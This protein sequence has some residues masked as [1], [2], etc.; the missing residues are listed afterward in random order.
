VAVGVTVG[1]DPVGGEGDARD[2]AT[3]AAPEA[4]DR[5]L[6][7]MGPKRLLIAGLFNF[8]LAIFAVLFGLFSQ[9]DDV[10]PF[11]PFSIDFWASV[12]AGTQLEAWVANHQW[13]AAVGGAITV[14][15]LGIATGIV[16]T[17][18]RDYGFRL[19]RT[20]RG[21]RRRRGL[22]TRTD[23]TVPAARVQAAVV[24]TG[25]IRRL[26]GWYDVRLSSLA[27]DGKDEA[28]HLVGPLVTLSEADHIIG[29][30]G[31]DRAGF[32]DGVGDSAQWQRQHKAV[33]LVWPVL[34]IG[35]AALMA[36]AGQ[37][38]D[39]M[40]AFEALPAEIAYVPLIPLGSALVV[41]VFGWLDWRHSRWW[42]D[43][44]LLHIADGFL[45]RTHIILPARNI[46]SADIAIGPFS[47]RFGLAELRLGVPGG[48]G[49]EHQISGMDEGTAR[50]LRDALLAVH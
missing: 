32:E 18:L 35:I 47:R 12:V 48:S 9:L 13:L 36:V 20:P 19:D 16:R 11:D 46:Q 1:V 44:R 31:L 24:G 28:D 6:L 5:L 14:L 10:L 45:T 22:T 7:T 40:G 23:V 43:G 2:A 15:L 39:A 42:F 17:V 21:F 27:S 41:L 4:D 26:L 50:A 34:L 37:V 25:L 49:G 3:D 30:L 33:V 29:E 38:A 8:S